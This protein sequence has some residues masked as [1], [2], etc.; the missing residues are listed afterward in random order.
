LTNQQQTQFNLSLFSTS[1]STMSASKQ[2]SAAA[3]ATKNSRSITKRGTGSAMRE[4]FWKDHGWTESAIP[5]NKCANGLNAI[6]QCGFGKDKADH[7]KDHSSDVGLSPEEYE[8]LHAMY[9]A[10]VALMDESNPNNRLAFISKI[11][12]VQFTSLANINEAKQ[13]MNQKNDQQ[14]QQHKTELENLTKKLNGLETNTTNTSNLVVKVGEDL[15]KTSNAIAG[16]LGGLVASVS[17]MYDSE[18]QD[19]LRVWSEQTFVYMDGLDNLAL[20]TVRP[21]DLA[22]AFELESNTNRLLPN[23]NW[24]W[25]AE[26]SSK[27]AEQASKAVE[28]C[29]QV[30]PQ[31]DKYTGP[32]TKYHLVSLLY[33]LSS[34]V[35]KQATDIKTLQDQMEGKVNKSDIE[36]VKEACNTATTKCTTAAE[37][38]TK[39]TEECNQAT[40]E[41]KH[42]KGAFLSAAKLHEDTVEKHLET[43][44]VVNKSKE[45]LDKVGQIP[46]ETISLLSDK[47]ALTALTSENRK[48]EREEKFMESVDEIVEVCKKARVESNDM[49]ELKKIVG[50]LA[51]ST[52]I[53]VDNITATVTPEKGDECS[54]PS[55]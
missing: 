55:P 17:K 7:K 54:S 35:A 49:A 16:C 29:G 43:E 41:C 28:N 45:I 23:P 15:K 38:C 25:P 4:K 21:A 36:T 11:Q 53:W 30:Q 9:A 31:E 1:F 24:I 42:N 14:Q 6:M 46:P 40:E 44:A 39:A 20:K 22:G 50:S 27:A 26:A 51:Q 33:D 3:A 47:E 8:K 37:A 48:R 12:N 18:G 19:P 5:K 52:K 13:E 32:I 10:D 2:A 34:T